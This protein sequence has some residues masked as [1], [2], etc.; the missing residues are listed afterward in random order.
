M[1]RKFKL[2]SAVLIAIAGAFALQSCMAGGWHLSR[3]LATWNN[4]F[5]I[6]P[7]ILIYIAL[8]ILPVYEIAALVDAFWFNIGDFWK[9]TVS[10][11]NQKYRRNGMDVCVENTRDP[12]RHTTITSRKGERI[13]STVELKELAGGKIAMYVNGVLRGEVN[14][15]RDVDLDLVLYRE[16]GKTVAF[17]KILSGLDLRVAESL[18]K[19]QPAEYLRALGIQVPTAPAYA[20]K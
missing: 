16:D 20:A 4:A 12:L 17:A 9:G 1:T 14:S 3:K 6:V 11:S 7:R 10:A 5:P 18:P 13:V 15:I 8:F 19:G 2:V